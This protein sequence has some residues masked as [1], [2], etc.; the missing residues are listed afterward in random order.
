[1]HLDANAAEI[2]LDLV[3]FKAELDDEIYRQ[4]IREHQQ[5]GQRSHLRATPTFFVNGV[6]QDISGG[7]R[8]L[9]DM[10]AQELHRLS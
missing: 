8:A 3:R 6:V 2:G 4:R 1:M 10:V 7:M 9:F 5:G